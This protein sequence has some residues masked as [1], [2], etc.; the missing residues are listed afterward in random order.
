MLL[1]F[2]PHTS[3]LPAR[4][5]QILKNTPDRPA[6]LS[7]PLHGYSP[8]DYRKL[9]ENVQ[10]DGV[11][12]SDAK[13]S[14][15][16]RYKAHHILHN[17]EVESIFIPHGSIVFACYTIMPFRSRNGPSNLYSPY[18]PVSSFYDQSQHHY[19]QYG[20]NVPSQVESYS[21]L[22]GHAYRSH[23][24]HHHSPI[25]SNQ[26][27]FQ[28]SFQTSG[29]NSPT[30]LRSSGTHSTYHQE[31][32][33]PSNA[34]HTSTHMDRHPQS[35]QIQRQAPYVDEVPPPRQRG[36]RLSPSPS[37]SG[38]SRGG[39]PPPGITMC[40]ACKS[41]SSPEWRKGPRGKKDLCNACGLRYSRQKAKKEG[42]SST[43]RRKEGAKS[44]DMD[45]RGGL[46]KRRAY[47]LVSYHEP[48]AEGHT[49][50]VSSPDTRASPSPPVD[51][52]SHRTVQSSHYHGVSSSLYSYPSSNS[53][54]RHDSMY[55]TS[56]HPSQPPSTY[57]HHQQQH[58]H[59]GSF[60]APPSPSTAE[61]SASPS[62]GPSRGVTTPLS[63]YERT[64]IH[65]QPRSGALDDHL[66][67]Q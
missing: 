64:G 38:T 3:Q 63:S 14:C 42:V 19:S 13:T 27:T 51:Y 59:T 15:T 17:T 56:S 30:G 46:S 6:L 53:E 31:S 12:G 54:S 4:V 23:A 60:F 9:A 2:F 8:S 26:P 22:H 52:S 40:A 41:T 47:G 45:S 11:N 18:T 37:G 61:F 5:F 58:H 29:R 1:S 36:S 16:R 10:I 44:E 49:T 62:S 43:K 65:G 50:L 48:G 67:D 57:T 24:S 20:L 39:Q 25:H 66:P 33:W 55:F 35:I 28:S 7:W 21:D 32:Q 34:S